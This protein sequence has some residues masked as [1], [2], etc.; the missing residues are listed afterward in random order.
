MIGFIIAQ[1]SEEFRWTAVLVGLLSGAAGGVLTRLVWQV[2]ADLVRRHNLRKTLLAQMTLTMK[3]AVG[4]EPQVSEAVKGLDELSKLVASRSL[5]VS[6]CISALAA[7]ANEFPIARPI[8]NLNVFLE[9]QTTE[10]QVLVLQWA[11]LMERA[12][13]VSENYRG[14]FAGLVAACTSWDEAEE[15]TAIPLHEHLDAARGGA[16]QLLRMLVQ[17]GNAAAVY[18]ALH[19]DDGFVKDCRLA[20]GVEQQ[21]RAY[22]DMLQDLKR[23]RPPH[24][25]RLREPDFAPD[26]SVF[27]PWDLNSVAERLHSR[28]SLSP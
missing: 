11:N 17:A 14:S 3:A 28:G 13:A 16:M 21:R 26:R 10:E 4:V 15:R 2:F 25:E 8:T 6:K 18:T 23:D 19:Q 5:T 20:A 1:G 9:H 22:T 24:A 12:V 27:F 7:V